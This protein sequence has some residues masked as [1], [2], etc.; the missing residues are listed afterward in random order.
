[1][2]RKPHILIEPDALHVASAA[3]ERIVAWARQAIDTRGR[4]TVALAGGSTPQAT[5]QRLAGEPHRDAVDWSRVHV[6][7]GDERCVPPADPNSNYGMAYESLL[8]K[9]PI[10][11]ENVHRMR[12]EL[13]PQIAAQ[14]YAGEL[15]RFFGSAWPRFDLV[16]LGMGADGHTASLFPGSPALDETQRAVVAVTADYQDRP[17]CRVTLS[18]PAI[19]AARAVVFIVTG[20]SKA[21][22]VQ[23]VLEDRQKH[24]PAQH[25]QPVE[26]ELCWLLDAAAASQLSAQA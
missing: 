10:P 5:Y 12:G 8:S 3:A 16:L 15:R 22:R 26:G 1:M 9:V 2:V 23:Q 6:F 18:L 4:F 24:L 19:N 13:D 11:S 17:S 7:W 21:R 14:A 25:V 20:E